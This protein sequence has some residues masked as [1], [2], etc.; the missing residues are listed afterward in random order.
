MQWFKF[1]GPGISSRW[2]VIIKAQKKEFKKELYDTKEG[3]KTN[4]AECKL[5]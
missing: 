2:K 4:K 1:Y 3:D 5:W